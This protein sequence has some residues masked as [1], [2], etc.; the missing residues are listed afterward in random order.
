[1]LNINDAVL[2]MGDVSSQRNVTDSN[3]K[4]SALIGFAVLA[5][6]LALVLMLVSA[7]AIN[8]LPRS[9]EGEAV[10]VPWPAC[11]VG[12]LLISVALPWT[13]SLALMSDRRRRQYFLACLL[14]ANAACYLLLGSEMLTQAY[15]RG[16]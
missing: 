7:S 8:A 9:M 4:C 3:L 14:V 5:S 15:N 10:L 2:S 11:L 12:S 13:V 1:M 16:L 6:F